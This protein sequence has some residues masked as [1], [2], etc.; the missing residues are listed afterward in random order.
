MWFP[1]IYKI[2]ESKI[3]GCISRQAANSK[4]CIDPLVTTEAPN[5]VLRCVGMNFTGL[6]HSGERILIVIGEKSRFSDVGIIK[7]MSFSGTKYAFQKMFAR[8]NNLEQVKTDIGSL[9]I[10]HQVRKCWERNGINMTE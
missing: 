7:G 3:P 2:I 4:A 6:S 5:Q 10:S 1:G 8:Y 9:F